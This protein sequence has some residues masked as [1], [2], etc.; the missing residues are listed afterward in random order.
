[1]ARNCNA[2]VLQIKTPRV[3][4]RGL[5]ADHLTDIARIGGD[6]KVAPMIMRATVP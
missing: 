5:N 3:V 4:L 6:Q 2:R 1:M